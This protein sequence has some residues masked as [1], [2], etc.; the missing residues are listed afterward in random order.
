MEFLAD[1]LQLCVTDLT[2]IR[3]NQTGRRSEVGRIFIP[4]NTI[5]AFTAHLPSTADRQLV[6]KTLSMESVSPL[7]FS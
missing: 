3:P 6:Y 2:E 5:A 1:I 7:L 4:T